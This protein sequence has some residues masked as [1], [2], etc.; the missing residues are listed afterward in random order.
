MREVVHF[1]E[2]FLL[3]HVTHGAGIEQNH[4]RSFLVVRESVAVVGH[5]AR[6]GFRIA[7]VHLAAVGFDENFFHRY[8]CLL[9]INAMI[10]VRLVTL[11]LNA[12]RMAEVTTDDP[13]FFTPRNVMQVCT[14]SS[15]TA[16]P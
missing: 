6:D 3:R 4:V 12:P 14:A 1:A 11:S 13:G 2:R 7:L 16:T 5:R 9:N 10:S 8:A 15:T